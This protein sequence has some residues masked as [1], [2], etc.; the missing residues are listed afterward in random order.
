M[1]YLRDYEVFDGDAGWRVFHLKLLDQT[2][3]TVLINPEP[4][5]SAGLHLVMDRGDGFADK[6]ITDVTALFSMRVPSVVKAIASLLDATTQQLWLHNDPILARSTDCM[7]DL[8]LASPGWTSRVPPCCP[9]MRDRFRIALEQFARAALDEGCSR[10]CA[11]VWPSPSVIRDY[12]VFRA[13]L[14]GCCLYGAPHGEEFVVLALQLQ[15]CLD[16]GL[17]G[18]GLMGASPG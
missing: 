10:V 13:E 9:P 16:V 8:V 15:S 18:C 17:S 3:A 4:A 5:I 6:V 1:L 7:T 2:Y 11:E 14:A 12:G